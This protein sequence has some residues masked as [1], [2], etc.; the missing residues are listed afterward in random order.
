MIFSNRDAKVILYPYEET[1]S[2][3]KNFNPELMICKNLK[4]IIYLNVKPKI[5][6]FPEEII[7]EVI[8]GSCDE[9]HRH[10]DIGT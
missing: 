2:E 9:Y 4:S 10:I 6:K 8:L 7:K 5:A 1:I 3:K